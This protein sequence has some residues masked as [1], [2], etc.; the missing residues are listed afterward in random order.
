MGFGSGSY[1]GL[2]YVAEGTFGADPA[3]Y[4]SVLE[5]RHT[6]CSLAVQKETFVSNE[7]RD[8]RQISDFR[9][10]VKRVAGDIGFEL[11]Y[12][13]YDS[14]LAAALFSSWSN[15]VL[16]AGTTEGSFQFERAFTDITQYGKFTGCMINTLSL[17]IPANGIITGS[18]GIV[19][20][21]GSY[22]GSPLNADPGASQ[23]NE[24]FDSFSGSIE[25]NDV[26]IAI[27]TSVEIN[28]ANGLTPAYVIGENTT[29]QIGVGR[30]NIT[31]TVSAYFEDA[32]L[33][34]KFLDESESSLLLQIGETED[35]YELELPKIKYS[36]GDNPVN[37][38]GLI[39]INMPF[40]ALYDATDESNIVITR[41]PSS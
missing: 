17:S 41:Y 40:Q 39:L 11:S 32:D 7:I 37:G 4:D 15:D 10:G 2:R 3:N 33:I 24:P 22:S 28:I 23:S 9:H 26:A 19:G 16:K 5:L 29:P 6:G 21:N 30:C 38:E 36:G 20:K 18:F 12:S 1:H 14:L 13:E 34:D 35:Y 8:D 25:E 27:V 31:G